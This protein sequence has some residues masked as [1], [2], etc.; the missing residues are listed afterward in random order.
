[1][2]QT[3]TLFTLGMFLLLACRKVPDLSQLSSN[4][5]VQTSRAPDAN[6]GDY[7]TFYISDTIGYIS[8]NPKDSILTDD[9]AKQIVAQ[10][11]GNL[12]ARG[13]R[14][15]PRV[16]RPDLGVNV[17]AVKDVDVGVVYPGWWYGYPGYWDPWY[18]G[19]YY[20]YYYPGRLLILL[21]PAA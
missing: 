14:Y 5:V 15:V 19:W 8:T 12:E 16:A 3:V 17:V 7:Q 10:I 11:R 4:F 6:F 2:K 20:P 9:A 21:L 18:W 13:Y 1:M